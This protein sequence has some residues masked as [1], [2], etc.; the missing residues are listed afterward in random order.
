MTVYR[1]QGRLWRSRT[2]SAASSEV[3]HCR[4][5]LN[6]G[7]CCGFDFYSYEKL[8]R[9]RIRTWELCLFMWRTAFEELAL[10]DSL[11]G[12]RV[13]LLE[14]HQRPSWRISS[15]STKKQLDYPGPP[16][17]YL[18]TPG[19]TYFYIIIKTASLSTSAHKLSEMGQSES[20][21][22]FGG[23]VSRDFNLTRSVRQN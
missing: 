15:F 8:N 12:L 3:H 16:C 1:A 23:G 2:E 13:L 11:L 14:G 19:S 5:A 21:I 22:S 10:G 17:P 7:S 9:G 18:S 20:S 4:F 6:G